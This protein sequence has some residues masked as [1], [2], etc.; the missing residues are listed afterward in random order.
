MNPFVSIIIPCFNHGLYIEEAIRSVEQITDK[1]IYEIIIINDGSTDG[2]TLKV[3]RDL[4]QNGYFILQQENKGLASARNNGIKL[5]KGKYFLPL[6]A[7]NRIKKDYIEK[8]IN[9]LNENLDVGIVYGNSLQFGDE[10]RVFIAGKYSLK[11]LMIKNYIDACAII[12]KEAWEQV[13][14]YDAT[15]SPFEDWDI[16]LSI[17]T[18]GWKFDYIPEIMFEYRILNNSM[19]RSHP[20]LQ[21]SI[22]NI[23]KKHGQLYKNEF[24]KTITISQRINSA[25]YDLFKKLTGNPNY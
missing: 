3:L 11:R 10:N 18:L 20:N 23:T 1:S 14:G 15:V 8:G 21:E 17:A 12:R 13:G 2:H 25:L 6:D 4:E 16:N 24:L 9:I 22:N 5:S 7:D 19:F